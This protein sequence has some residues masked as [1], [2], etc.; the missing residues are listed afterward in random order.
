MP[1]I[2][3]VAF[4][5]LVGSF[6][7]LWVRRDPRI[8]G[9]LLGAS[10]LCGF[11]S[12]NISETG[13]VFIAILVLLWILYTRKQTLSL[14]ILLVCIG[15]AFKLRLFPGYTPYFFTHKFAVGLEMPLIG[16]LPLAFLVPLARSVKDWTAVINGLL[17][18]CVGISI[19]AVLATLTNVTQWNF[20]LPTFATERL[21]SNLFLT[22]IP[23]E[24]FYRGFIQATLCK[25]FKNVKF[26]KFFSLIV[27]S[28]LF[29]AVHLYWSPDLAT[30]GFVFLASMLYGGVYLISRRIESA[31]LC[32]FLLN[33]IHMTFF[34]YHA[35]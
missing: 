22:C 27:T 7:S 26:G 18:G 24:G 32:H 10:V 14:F 30:L 19:L 16:L 35:M 13:L 31:I 28:I 12:G 15:T 34:S 1:L 3:L 4:V 8:W 17:I 11:V 33:F 9:T 5:F 6:L 25:Y 29:T 23:E 21:L 2:T 20:K